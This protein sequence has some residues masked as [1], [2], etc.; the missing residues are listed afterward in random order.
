MTAGR[1]RFSQWADATQ[2]K[3]V[4]KV[5]PA[6]EVQKP[7]PKEIKEIRVSSNGTIPKWIRVVYQPRVTVRKSPSLNAPSVAFLEA[8]EIVEIAEIKQGWV[9]LADAEKHA[10]DVSEDCDAWVLQDGKA[11][12]LGLLL[13]ECEPRWFRVVYEPRVP[14]RMKASVQAPAIAFL[15]A[16]TVIEA[17]EVWQGWVRLSAQD[18]QLLDISDDCGSWVL[19]DGYAKGAG[20][21]LEWLPGL[22]L[23]GF[24]WQD[25]AQEAS[26]PSVASRR[27]QKRQE[28]ANI[29]LEHDK[30]RTRELRAVHKVLQ[31]LQEILPGL[32]PK[33]LRASDAA[34]GKERRVKHPTEEE[35]EGALSQ[36]AL[37]LWVPCSYRKLPQ[38]FAPREGLEVLS[39]MIDRP[40]KYQEKYLEQEWSI[41]C[42]VWAL[43]PSCGKGLAVVDIG[44]GN[45]SLALLAALLLGGHAVLIDHTL[46]PEPM[47]VE[48]RLPEEYRQRVLR[49]TGDVGDLD[50]SR[51]IEPLLEKH[52]ITQVVV[53][54]KHLCG[55]GTDLA[56]KLL[57]RW[58][59]A[60]AE[61]KVDVLGAVI[62]TC[63]MHKIGA[64]EDRRIYSEIHSADPYL[65]KLMGKSTD[66]LVSLLGVCT[67]CVAWR[68]TAGAE[69]SRITEK[70]VKMAEMFEDALQQ[71]RSNLLQSLF[72]SAIEV[73]FVPFHR[74]PQNRC[75]I[76]GSELGVQRALDTGVFASAEA[77]S[78]L[79]AIAAARDDVLRVNGTALD[80]RPHGMV[81]TRFG[82]DGT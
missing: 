60:G 27:R 45:G 15:Q 11:V 49:V 81:S 23:E 56:L 18:R 61:T 35:V 9:R 34:E 20:R 19:I 13:E 82:Y 29:R 16:G 75:L 67:P 33:T 32:A 59:Q 55:T 52:G 1:S 79:S 65:R 50:A 51:E 31:A 3:T 36:A 10:R 37:T 71:P 12:S 47:R 73:A 28:R 30:A 41:L 63:C 5:E 46:P 77:Q 17:E 14:V 69:A 25:D 62:A 76:A 7:K 4:S 42:K 21:L 22:S 6:P 66:P 68:T 64:A 8:G 39:S 78:V 40:P 72:P 26:K 2:G 80:L 58:C 38:I 53:I 57:R 24:L 48:G 54:A 74:S 44:A 70:Q 43:A